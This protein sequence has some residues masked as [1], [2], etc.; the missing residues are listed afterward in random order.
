MNCKTV[1]LKGFF[2]PSRTRRF[3][4]IFMSEEKEPLK[5]ASKKRTSK[6]GP[7]PDSCDPDQTWSLLIFK[8]KDL[9]ERLVLRQDHYTFGRESE[10]VDVVTAHESC[11]KLHA[12]I[13]FLRKGDKAIP[14]VLDMESSNGTTLNDTA[15]Q[16]RRYYEMRSGDVIKFGASTRDYV[17]MNIKHNV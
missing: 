14:Y 5:A 2:E 17:I 3:E 16:P 4:Q 1:K 13:Q 10:G 15:L 8:G 9:L 7:P 12:V 6:Y 11:S